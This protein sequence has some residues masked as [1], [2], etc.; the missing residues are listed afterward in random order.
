MAPDRRAL[1]RHTVLLFSCLVPWL[2]VKF[3]I[4]YN[5]FKLLLVQT[6]VE[7]G[8]LKCTISILNKRLNY[9]TENMTNLH[10]LNLKVVKKI[11]NYT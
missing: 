10:C 3:N 5:I 6:N 9:H 1:V 11:T 8:G 2:F 7:F 4:I